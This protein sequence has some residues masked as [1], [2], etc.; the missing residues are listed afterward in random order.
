[1]SGLLLYLTPNIRLAEIP[2]LAVQTFPSA[3]TIHTFSTVQEGLR[4]AEPRTPLA[5]YQSVPG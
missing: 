4:A 2:P 5:S 1:M 3:N